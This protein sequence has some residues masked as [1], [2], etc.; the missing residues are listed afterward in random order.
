MSGR[1]LDRREFLVTA[2][3]ATAPGAA[4]AA[5][6]TED[7]LWAALRGGGHVALLRHALAPGTGDPPG[8]RLDDCSTQRN[9][10][11]DGRAQARAIGAVLRTRGIRP[12][13]VLS[14]RWCRCRETA[15]LLGLGAVELLPALDSF[16]EDRRRG[17]AQTEA[18]RRHLAGIPA[19]ETEVLVTHQV[20]VTA[21]TGVFPRSADMVVV[22]AG[23][24]GPHTLGRLRVAG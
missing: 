16:F 1:R 23:P 8:F 22:R 5:A 14:S 4:F 21:L 10:S 12:A 9:L 18:L 20:N 6:P 11:D 17:P 3:A 24:A 2:L 19:H 13:R 15:E 7:Q